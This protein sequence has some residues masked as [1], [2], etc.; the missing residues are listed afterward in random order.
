M[1][2]E[3]PKP[4]GIHENW[5]A[6]RRVQVAAPIANLPQLLRGFF[7]KAVVLVLIMI[8]ARVYPQALVP[9]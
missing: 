4:E 3:I 8:L 7:R 6:L 1:N 9:P 5:T 2:L